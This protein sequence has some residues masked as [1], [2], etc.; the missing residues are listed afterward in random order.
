[1]TKEELSALIREVGLGHIEDK[2]MQ[3]ARPSLR[4]HLHPVDEAAIPVGGTKFGGGAD[5]PPGFEWP[6]WQ[7]YPESDRPRYRP[8]EFSTND[9]PQ[10]FLLQLRLEDLAA[11][12]LEGVLPTSGIL[13]FFCAT[14]KSALGWD[15]TDRDC[16]KVLHYDGDLSSLARR[17]V[18]PTG[19]DWT[20][21]PL[22]CLGIEF[23]HQWTLPDGNDPEPFEPLEGLLG[24]DFEDP[25]TEYA[26]Y[27]RL[28]ELIGQEQIGDG[29]PIH[30]LLGLPQIVQSGRMITQNH[31]PGHDQEWRL[32]LQIDTEDV[33]DTRK[34]DAVTVHWQLSGRG[35]FYIPTQ[36]LAERNFDA[37]WVDMQCT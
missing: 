15:E 2:L 9:G 13:Y 17:L 16:W 24:G 36:A 4:L 11:Y 23:Q 35:Y 19:S 32:L 37:V 22:T 6:V 21:Q 10:E 1:M 28:L 30:R 29:D 34:P 31:V 8:G 20:D 12:D 14:W 33:Y 25:E 18:A 27:L 3:A 26:R 7:G 5:L